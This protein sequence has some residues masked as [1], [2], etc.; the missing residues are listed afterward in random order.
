MVENFIGKHYA[1][2]NVARERQCKKAGV[3]IKFPGGSRN[4]SIIVKDIGD[5]P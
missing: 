4:Y 1:D 5:V 2:L 3:R